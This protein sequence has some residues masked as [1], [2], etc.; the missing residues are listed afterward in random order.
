[1]SQRTTPD[2]D[3]DLA[4]VRELR[5]DLDLDLG[6][7][8]LEAT[9]AVIGAAAPVAGAAL[10]AKPIAVLAKGALSK[11]VGALLLVATATGVTLAVSSHGGGG[12]LADRASDGDP[13]E[14][15]VPAPGAVDA[16]PTR[17]SS[18]SA[19]PASFPDAAVSAVASGPS[20]PGGRSST[21]APAPT[22]PGPRPVD[23]TRLGDELRDVAEARD[24]LATSPE[25][26]LRRADVS[27]GGQ[28][29]QERE[30]IAIRALL[31]LGRHA[32]AR[33]RAER[34]L[35]RHPESAFRQNARRIV[36]QAAPTPA[37]PAPAAGQ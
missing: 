34:F 26:A 28:L 25:A 10:A 23:K 37:P 24:L 3:V 12:P 22:R 6:A 8:R 20:R 7:A 13:R 21:L 36:D 18:S 15:R 30:I 35:A 1:M 17:A 5:V 2:L 33:A 9:L 29:D 14:A 16:E 19:E 27:T 32:E 31:A 4:R 11:A